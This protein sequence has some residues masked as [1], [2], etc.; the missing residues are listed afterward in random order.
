MLA[1]DDDDDAGPLNH[2][3][4]L[5][6]HAVRRRSGHLRRRPGQLQAGVTHGGGDRG[7]LQR[8]ATGHAYPRRA[9]VDIDANYAVQQADLGLQGTDALGR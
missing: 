7:P 1:G 4:R 3:G 8:L 6:S 5:G 2:S 9:W